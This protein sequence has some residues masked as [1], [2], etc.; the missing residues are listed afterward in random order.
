M[1]KFTVKRIL[2]MFVSLLLISLMVFTIFEFMPG[3]PALMH[4]SGREDGM[5][6]EEWQAEL[7]AERVVMGLDGPYIYRYYRWIVNMIQGNWGNSMIHRRPVLEVIRVP[8]MWTI[9][10]SLVSTTIG[11][12]LTIPLGI[13]SAVKR[14]KTADNSIMVFTMMGFSMPTFLVA[15]LFIVFLAVL[16]QVFPIAGMSSPIPPDTTWLRFLDRLRHMALPLFTLI[17]VSLAGMTRYVR[18]QMCDAL[19]EDYIR[20]AK[21]KGLKDKVVIFSHAFRN[22]LVPIVTMMAGTLVGIFGGSVVIERTFNWAGMGVVMI[23]S[24][25]GGDYAVVMAVLLFYGVVTLVAILLMD[26]TYGL[27]DPRIRVSK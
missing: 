10:L 2:F 11:F 24:I 17:F 12:L 4:M 13:L 26:L 7:A 19:T 27:V 15:I 9:I 20:T 16:L 22:A 6:A 25:F 1:L 23:N 14:G 8:I 21:S 3:D 18:G 5:T